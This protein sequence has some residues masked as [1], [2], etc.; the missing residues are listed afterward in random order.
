M[1][2]DATRTRLVAVR[3]RAERERDIATFA[4]TDRLIGLLDSGRLTSRDWQE[5]AWETGNGD[6]RR[7]WFHE[8]VERLA[9]A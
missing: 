4:N 9:S 1:R 5:I 6:D 7:R 2:D 8:T 3:D